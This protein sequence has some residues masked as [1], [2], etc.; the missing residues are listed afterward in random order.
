ML[1]IDL[2][3]KVKQKTKSCGHTVGTT[4]CQNCVTCGN[5]PSN[6]ETFEQINEIEKGK[7]YCYGR[8]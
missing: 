2:P 5:C 3:T 6:I 8:A 1:E 7:E 4:G